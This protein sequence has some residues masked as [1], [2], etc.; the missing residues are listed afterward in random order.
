[1]NSMKKFLMTSSFVAAFLSGCTLYDTF[2]EDLIPG[3]EA[4]LSSSSDEVVSS[5]SEKVDDPLSSASDEDDSSSS[6]KI[7]DEIK[8]S[9]SSQSEKSS[10]SEDVGESSSSVVNCEEFFEDK[11]DGNQYKT[12]NINGQCWF[13][14]NLKFED[15]S[16]VCFE[17]STNPDGDA[18]CSKYGRLYAYEDAL[19]ACPNGSYLPEEGDWNALVEYANGTTEAGELLKAEEFDGVDQ[20]KFS[21][22]MGGSCTSSS[23]AKLE[24]AGYWWTTKSS[25]VSEAFAFTMN[26]IR[27]DVTEMKLDKAKALSVRCIV[28]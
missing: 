19:V 1:M 14:E 11:R 24:T 16:S 4:S 10:S 5:S 18:N 20:L 28:K 21:A 13:A 7:D 26:S 8:S 17:N 15:G 27:T 12:V 9:S 2:D 25:T 23:C 6:E 22:L 3:E